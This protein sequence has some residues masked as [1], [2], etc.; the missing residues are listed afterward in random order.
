MS[1][2]DTAI[3]YAFALGLVSALNPCGFPLLPAYLAFFVAVPTQ[4][5]PVA[6]TSRGLVAGLSVTVGFVVVFSAA[7]ALVLLGMHLVLAWAPWL[8]I[9]VGVTLAAAGAWTLTGR[10]LPVKLPRVRPGTGRGAVP[11]IGY[12]IV[13]AIGSLGCSLPIFLAGVAETFTRASPL[14]AGSVF[15]AYALG[16]GVFVT[17]AGLIASHLGATGLRS[18]RPVTRFLPRF[19]AALLLLAGLYL[20]YY[21]IADLTQPAGS[22]APITFVDGVQAQLTGAVERF[23][24]PVAGLL[25]VVVVGA[26]AVVARHERRR[27]RTESLSEPPI[28]KGNDRVSHR[29]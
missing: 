6:R 20:T 19:G 16:M 8:M 10:S 18:F 4:N 27:A 14:V 26:F 21:W 7:G 24:L 25:A 22:S 11:M 3:G 29:S 9:G 13:Y 2:D 28:L 5:G 12:G 15:L 17:G 23:G 1:L